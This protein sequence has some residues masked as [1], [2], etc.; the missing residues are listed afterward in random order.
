[1][2]VKRGRMTYLQH[3]EE[4]RRRIIVCIVAVSAGCGVSWIFA[5]DI[6]DIL[7]GPAGNITLHYLKPMEPFL[8]RFKLT[9]FGGVLLALPVVLFEVLAFLSP[10]LKRKD[11][12]FTIA[13][14]LMILAFFSAGVA[15][16]YY[17]I[18][19]VGITWLLDLAAGQMSPVLSASEYV[20]F[21]GW[22][23]LAFGIAFETPIFIWML[24]ALG[25]LTPEQLRRQWR[26]AYIIILLFAAVITPDWN[27]ITMLMVAVPMVLLYEMSI[28]LARFTVGKRKQVARTAG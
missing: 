13:V 1:M 8:V 14:M 15:L 24:V 26:Y 25:V 2:A 20:S 23:M 16:G 5:W 17:Y 18:M 21:A 12:S 28:L 10:A 4:L 9:L 19:P 7:K 27:P 11:R 3:L 22:F 6:L